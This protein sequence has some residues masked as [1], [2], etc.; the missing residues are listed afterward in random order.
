MTAGRERELFDWLY[1]TKAIHPERITR[2]KGDRYVQCYA[3]PGAMA[4]GFEYYRALATSAA[5][6]H[7]VEPKRLFMPVLALGG[8]GG[9]GLTVKNA[10]ERMAPHVQGGEIADCGHYVAEEQPEA[11]AGRLL[12][13]W[14]GAE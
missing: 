14:L 8:Q 6:N 9:A 13:F 1:E 7:K 11:L 4:R 10:N 5:Q 2:A 12:N 3:A